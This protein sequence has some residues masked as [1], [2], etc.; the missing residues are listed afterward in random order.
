M[1]DAM[2]AEAVSS[3]RPPG[4]DGGCGWPGAP[5]VAAGRDGDGNRR[6]VARTTSRSTPR[7]G[8]RRGLT[9]SSDRAGGECAR[10]LPKG[11]VAPAQRPPL[12]G[13]RAVFDALGGGARAP[14][15]VPRGRATP[16]GRGRRSGRPT[17]WRRA[18]ARSEH[19]RLVEEPHRRRFPHDH[20]RGSRVGPRSVTVTSSA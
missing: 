3:G 15:T 10:C 13:Q 17:I 9:R 11:T 2:T 18:S 20:G 16:S 4:S 12:G 8:P 6:S 7:A 5:D 19:Q 1:L 14:M